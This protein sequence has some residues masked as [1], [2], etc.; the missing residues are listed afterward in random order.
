MQQITFNTYSILVTSIYNRVFT[1]IPYTFQVQGYSIPLKKREKSLNTYKK[2][3]KKKKNR[4]VFNLNP[5]PQ[6]QT[7]G[8]QQQQKKQFY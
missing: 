2:E 5:V 1:L 7:K 8:K 3:S 6:E 4:K